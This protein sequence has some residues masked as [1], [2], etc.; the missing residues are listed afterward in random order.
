MLKRTPKVA[1]K[2]AAVHIHV[3]LK[4]VDLGV[5]VIHIFRFEKGRIVELWEA[6]QP[7][8]EQSPN[9]YGIF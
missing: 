6:G 9:Q 5:A 2:P 4:P 3:R 7:V 1:S 8:P